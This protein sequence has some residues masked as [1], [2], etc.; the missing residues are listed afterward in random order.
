[1]LEI[2]KKG[3]KKIKSRYAE[4]ASEV[5]LPKEKLIEISCI[6]LNGADRNPA[7][8]STKHKATQGLQQII[9]PLHAHDKKAIFLQYFV[10]IH[11]L[12]I[13]VR[14]IPDINEQELSDFVRF[15]ILNFIKGIQ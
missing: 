6:S 11:G 14:D 15:A 13:I 5:Q 10:L 4:T 1:L 12:A 8:L 9:D 7:I 3:F 2:Q